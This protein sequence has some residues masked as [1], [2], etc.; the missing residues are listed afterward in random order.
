MKKIFLFC[1]LMLMLFSST[2]LAYGKDI[3][4]DRAAIGSIHLWDTVKMVRDKYGKPS[5]ADPWFYSEQQEEDCRME[6]YAPG[7]E[8]LVSRKK[9]R[10][11]FVRIYHGSQWTTPDGIG[12]GASKSDV[13]AAYGPYDPPYSEENHYVYFT[14]NGNLAFDFK[15]DE[16]TEIMLSYE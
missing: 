1:T 11:L 13:R 5:Q 10:V 7:N 16:V 3:P 9:G 15:D 4:T 8:L 14:Q 2:C 12:I 6:Y